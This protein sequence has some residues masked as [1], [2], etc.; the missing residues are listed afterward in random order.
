MAVVRIRW[1]RGTAAEWAA[2]NPV[3]ASGEPGFET[4]TGNFKIG[5]GEKR[6]LELDYS[7]GISML[8]DL[9]DVETTDRVDGSVLVYDEATNKFVA[10]PL[11]TKITLTDGGSF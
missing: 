10:G 5:N 4:D 2:A 9:T 7:T 1:R 3:L 11:D 6:W 8:G